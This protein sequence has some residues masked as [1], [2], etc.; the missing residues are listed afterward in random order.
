[1]KINVISGNGSQ[2]GRL[3]LL[4]L[5]YCLITATAWADDFEIVDQPL[6]NGDFANG[7]SEW[8]VNISPDSAVPA[9]SVNVVNGAAR[10]AK[11]GAF[12]AELSQGFQAPEG[13]IAMRMTLTELP[14]FGSN[15]SFVP[16]AFDVHLI[17]GNGFSR[18]ASFRAGA[19]AAAN[20][21]AVPAGFNLG[22]GVTLVGST[23]RIS[24]EGVG[25]G[26]SLLFAVTLA[27]ASADS[28][29]T[30]AIDN[31]VLEVEQKRPPPDPP[32]PER[33]DACEMFRDSFEAE[34]GLGSVPRCPLG[35]VGDTG[36]TACAGDIGEECPFAA[37]PGQ[38]ADYGRDAR[39]RAGALA[40]FGG[41]PAGFDYTKL[42]ASGDALPQSAESWS[43]VLDNYTGLVWEVKIDDPLDPRHHEHTFSWFQSDASNDGGQ[44][45]LAD[46]GSCNGSICDTEGLVTVINDALLCGAS[47]WRMPT[48]E[49]LTS[50]VNA[51]RR[52]PALAVELFPWGDGIYWS[53]T[54]MAADTASAWLIDFSDGRAGVSFKSVPHRLRL[55]REVQ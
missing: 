10:L 44:P 12:V 46:G 15:G 25:P 4:A 40:K 33:V 53:G 8:A 38:D 51:G 17:G 39:A 27:G 21:T 18:V 16:E 26:E 3:T 49:E 2:F 41:G 13:L 34:L 36:I 9:G 43:C 11:G 55:V 48:R 5:G 50:L 22:D 54:P 47:G 23:L 29:A 52:D 1:M 19:N 14:V 20:S 30:A 42:D 7:L 31:V 37:L 24:L 28:V 35:Q 6:P 45:G 32:G